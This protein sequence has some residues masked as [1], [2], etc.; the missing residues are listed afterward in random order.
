M[1]HIVRRLRGSSPVV[2]SSRKMICGLVMVQVGHQ[3]QVLFPCQQIVHRRE[4]TGDPDYRAHRPG[5]GRNIMPGNPYRPA[6]GLHQRG[7]DV[8]RRRLTRPIRAEQG[9]D[10][11]RRNI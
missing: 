6:V 11:A 1:F 10:R 5:L 8:H 4:L 7:Q 9:K 3:L 2:G